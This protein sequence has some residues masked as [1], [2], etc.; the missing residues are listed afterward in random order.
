MAQSSLE[1]VPKPA[2]GSSTKDWEAYINGILA[3]EVT[4]SD[5]LWE[6]YW[7]LT[8]EAAEESPNDTY[9]GKVPDVDE[10]LLG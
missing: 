1:T 10:K 2:P 7:R 3:P 5:E 6:E 4:A 9:E 8:D